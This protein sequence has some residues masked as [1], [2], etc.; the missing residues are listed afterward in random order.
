[1]L[2]S[3]PYTA[4]GEKCRIFRL[5]AGRV[6]HILST[7]ARRRE[8]NRPEGG[9]PTLFRSRITVSPSARSSNGRALGSSR[10]FTPPWQTKTRLPPWK[11]RRPAD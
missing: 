3:S 7:Q 4:H 2:G 11:R 8:Q 5:T 9:L 1:M 10:A 6:K